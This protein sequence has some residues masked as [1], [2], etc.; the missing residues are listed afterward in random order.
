MYEAIMTAEVACTFYAYFGVILRPVAYKIEW[1]RAERADFVRF[2]MAI[3]SFQ[4]R[5]GGFSHTLKSSSSQ[6]VK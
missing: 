2:A 3:L 6:H 4:S 5:L 1:W